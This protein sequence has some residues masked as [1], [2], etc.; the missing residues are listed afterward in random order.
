MMTL[1]SIE[2]VIEHEG[3][4]DDE[5]HSTF[6]SREAL[7]SNAFYYLTRTNNG[8]HMANSPDETVTAFLRARGLT[9]N[10]LS[11]L[12]DLMEEHDGVR[13]STVNQLKTFLSSASGFAY[14][15]GGDARDRVVEFMLNQ[16]GINHEHIA[17]AV[18]ELEVDDEPNP[19]NARERAKSI[20]KHQRADA[21]A[22]FLS[23]PMVILL[24]ASTRDPADALGSYLKHCGFTDAE[25]RAGLSAAKRNHDNNVDDRFIN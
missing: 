14:L 7:V 9:D 10:D 15:A 13:T 11:D 18:A 25:I 3:P 16:P 19:F 6:D 23:D 21:I 12:A 2:E 17:Q 4:V 22:E 1:M 5:G 8:Y 24:A 20:P